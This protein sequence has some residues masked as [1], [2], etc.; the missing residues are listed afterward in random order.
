MSDQHACTHPTTNALCACD[1]W[2][3]AQP[4]V[5]QRSSL[6]VAS[7]SFVAPSPQHSQAQLHGT[8]AAAQH[9]HRDFQGAA[10]LA[11]SVRLSSCSW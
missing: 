4:A 8:K 5:M 3:L 2:R 7:A 10:H 6:Q 1:V 9:N 11:W